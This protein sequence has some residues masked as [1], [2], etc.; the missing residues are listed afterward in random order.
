M[1]KQR[2]RNT[3]LTKAVMFFDQTNRPKLIIDNAVINGGIE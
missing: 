2:K 1:L 3:L